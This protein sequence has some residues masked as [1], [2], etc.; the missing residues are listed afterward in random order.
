MYIYISFSAGA[1]I[2]A[3]L[4]DS[5]W[6]KCFLTSVWKAIIYK[7]VTTGVITEFF[8]ILYCQEKERKV[9][10]KFWGHGSNLDNCLFN[11]TVEVWHRAEQLKL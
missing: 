1:E 4:K 8:L 7:L 6:M 9:W 3:L 10:H 11:V 2:D 5:Q